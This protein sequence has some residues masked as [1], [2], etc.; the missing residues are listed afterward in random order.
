MLLNFIKL[1]R[2]PNLIIV[3]AIQYI[4]RW[5]IVNPL[6][7]TNGFEH[8]FD[9]LSFALLVLS[10]VLITASGYIINDYFD[11]ESDLYN[12]P[13]RVTVGK[14]ISKKRAMNI[15][16]ALNVI[17]VAISFYIS[18]KIGIFKLG[19]VFVII[20]GLLWF[21]SSSYKRQF[22]IGNL[23][24]ALLI[25][26][27][28]FMVAIFE[29]PTLNQVYRDS[30]IQTSRNFNQIIFWIAGFSFFAFF[31]TL[32]REIIKDIEDLEGDFTFGSNTLPIIIGVFYSKIIVI[33]LIVLTIVAL[34]FVHFSY[35]GNL[36]S[37]IYISV[38]LVIPFL[39]LIYK[40]ILAKT[41]ENF[42]FAS[43]VVKIIMVLGILY[44]FVV[45]FNTLNYL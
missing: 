1:V 38:L 41:K 24:I 6:L 25:G 19:F 34:Y 5:C 10:T 45:R 27:V 37:L 8:Q 12:K 11:T 7:V 13:D 40:L 14:S 17:A 30:L 31:V 26:L 32:I 43:N 21:Y 15:H 9:E 2:L 18:I 29:V 42:H 44:S 39:F 36:N 4:M 23:I 22:L 16:I 33:S 35:I 3:A 28:P 20:A